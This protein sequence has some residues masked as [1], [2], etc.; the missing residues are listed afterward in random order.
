MCARANEPP[1]HTSAF[2]WTPPPQPTNGVVR[3]AEGKALCCR[4][5][6]VWISSLERI[7]RGAS[8]DEVVV[9]RFG[10]CVG[11]GMGN[12]RCCTAVVPVPAS[13]QSNYNDERHTT[14]LCTRVKCLNICLRDVC[15]TA[16]YEHVLTSHMTHTQTDHRD[17]G[18]MRKAMLNFINNNYKWNS[19]WIRTLN[20][21][22]RI[23]MQPKRT[24]SECSSKHIYVTPTQNHKLTRYIHTIPYST[25]LRLSPYAA[26]GMLNEWMCRCRHS[27]LRRKGNSPTKQHGS[28][29]Y[30]T[31]QTE[32]YSH[33]TSHKLY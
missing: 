27:F 17:W 25:S 24:T 3:R 32:S 19:G 23:N 29:Y 12:C 31:L 15:T 30:C 33:S 13:G 2:P 18:K 5:V 1:R 8:A 9:V 22:C 11:L 21:F 28:C 7:A 6:C 4:R 14:V 10:F 26:C 20:A 16:A